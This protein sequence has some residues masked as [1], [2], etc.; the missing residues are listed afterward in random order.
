MQ[1]IQ[2]NR[3]SAA[4]TVTSFTP[5]LYN[6]KMPAA[7]AAGGTSATGTNASGEGTDSDILYG[8]VFNFQSGWLWV[9]TSDERI[10]LKPAEIIGLKLPAAPGSSTTITG[11]IIFNE[12]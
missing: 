6:S 10:V 11:G 9:P 1:R 8:D 12:Y 5:L 3:K 2:I 7:D 4:A